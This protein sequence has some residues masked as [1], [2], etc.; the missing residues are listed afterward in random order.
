MKF[1]V[2]TGRMEFSS[3]EALK[4]VTLFYAVLLNKSA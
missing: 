1:P 3:R 4:A 2:R